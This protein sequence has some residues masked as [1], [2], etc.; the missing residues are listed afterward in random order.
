[1]AHLTCETGWHRHRRLQVV[2]S[3]QQSL[4][5]NLFSHNSLALAAERVVIELEWGLDADC[6]PL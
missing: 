5:V 3:H 4:L 6:T 2:P 1:M